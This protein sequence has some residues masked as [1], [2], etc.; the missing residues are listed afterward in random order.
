MTTWIQH[1]Q[2]VAYQSEK[3]R[4]IRAVIQHLDQRPP[5]TM[6]EVGAGLAQDSRMMQRQWHC[7]CVL[8]DVDRSSQDRS[9][10][11][12]DYGDVASMQAY[13]SLGELR[14]TLH[15]DHPDFEYSMLD[16]RDLGQHSW[17]FDLIYSNRS[18][19][20]HY[21]IH[22]YRDWIQQHSHQNTVM[23]AQLRQGIRHQGI[24]IQHSIM[25]T[26]EWQIAQFVWA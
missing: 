11:H 21:P 9:K 1:W 14:Q 20:F 4:E 10:R 24:R 16:G 8:L 13:H 12:K 17:R 19:G 26:H 23:I 5:N 3:Q 25:S 7:E 6:L 18:W 2:S 15:R 22:T